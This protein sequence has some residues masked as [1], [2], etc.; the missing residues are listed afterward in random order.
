MIS[1]E[2]FGASAPGEVIFR[3]LGFTVEHLC[4]VARGV[5]EGHLRGVVSAS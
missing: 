1:L 2:R 3:E 4:E 5:L